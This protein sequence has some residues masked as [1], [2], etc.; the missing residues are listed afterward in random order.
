MDMVI[1]LL[2]EKDLAFEKGT[3]KTKTT[4]ID[5]VELAPMFKL[6]RNQRKESLEQRET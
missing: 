1:K 4:V 5:T 2:G 3:C 6:V